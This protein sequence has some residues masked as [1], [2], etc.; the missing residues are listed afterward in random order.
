LQVG[1]QGRSVG[2]IRQNDDGE[3]PDVHWWANFDPTTLPN[4]G[5]CSFLPVCWGG[6]PKKHLDNDMHALEE[7]SIY[8]RTNLPRLVASR[9]G[10][11]PVPGFEYSEAE[12]FR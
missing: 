4:C 10:L 12:Q 5:R 11:S 2:S 6:C 8:W 3:F 7:Q 1:E 9:F